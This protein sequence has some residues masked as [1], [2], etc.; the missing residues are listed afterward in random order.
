MDRVSERRDDFPAEIDARL[1]GL[2]GV[3]EERIDYEGTAAYII[4]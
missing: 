3:R 4:G 1:E 2:I